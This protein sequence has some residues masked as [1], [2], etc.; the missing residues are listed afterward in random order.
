M[1]RATPTLMAVAQPTAVR[2]LLSLKI[3][4]FWPFFDG[5]PSNRELVNQRNRSLR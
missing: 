1:D 5:R 4:K 3:S 2:A